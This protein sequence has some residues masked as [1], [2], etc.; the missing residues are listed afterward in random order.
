MLTR[1]R[2]SSRKSR[3]FS[4]QNRAYA[5]LTAPVVEPSGGE[6]HENGAEHRSEINRR[7]VVRAIKTRSNRVLSETWWHKHDD[8]S[9]L[10]FELF[11]VIARNLFL[12]PQKKVT[13]IPHE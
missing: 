12:N 3:H 8:A 7:S 6:G 10:T 9:Q 4:G 5:T 11:K 13:E 1:R 2:W